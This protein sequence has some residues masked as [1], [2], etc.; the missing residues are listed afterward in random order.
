M[1]PLSFAA[2]RAHGASHEL[3][4]GEKALAGLRLERAGRDALC[5]VG[6]RSYRIAHPGWASPDILQDDAGRELARLRHTFLGRGTLWRADAGEL[7][8]RRRLPLG[9]EL[10]AADGSVLVRA[11]RRLS[12]ARALDVQVAEP[13]FDLDVPDDVAVLALLCHSMLRRERA[14]S[15]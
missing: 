3:R 7:A 4:D 2:A 1:R 6:D 11:T 8:W 13:A 12:L 9:R 10:R 15:G 5:R 14:G